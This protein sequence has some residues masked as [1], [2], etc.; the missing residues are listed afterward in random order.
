LRAG[1]FIHEVDIL[2]RGKVWYPAALQPSAKRT[3]NLCA[4]IRVFRPI[5]GVNPIRP[6]AEIHAH[7]WNAKLAQP[8]NNAATDTALVNHH[9]ACTEPEERRG[10]LPGEGH[11]V[12]TVVNLN[13]VHRGIPATAWID[14]TGVVTKPGHVYAEHNRADLRLNVPFHCRHRI[15]IR[16][17]ALRINPRKFTLTANADKVRVLAVVLNPPL[18]LLLVRKRNAAG[19]DLNRVPAMCEAAKVKALPEPALIPC[20]VSEAAPNDLRVF[21]RERALGGLPNHRSE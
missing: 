5:V 11:S 4:L 6:R 13:W 10:D 14:H 19:V 3:P 12:D 2:P 20:G 7:N 18:N 15:F 9:H 8:V 1:E 16:D 21:V 17:E